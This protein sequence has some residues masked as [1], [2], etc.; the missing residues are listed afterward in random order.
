MRADSA[1]S[2]LPRRSAHPA[3][4]D[5]GHAPRQSLPV[6]LIRLVARLLA[7][8]VLAFALTAAGVAGHALWLVHRAGGPDPAAAIVVL[9]GGVYA[10]GSPGPDT[11]ARTRH[12]IA[13]YRAGLAP[14]LHFTGGH[15]NPD[16]PGTGEGMRAAA[17][18]A[19][20]PAAATSAESGSRSTLQNALLSRAALGPLAGAPVILVSDG[21]H[22]ARAWASFRWAGYGPVALSAATAFGEGSVRDRA[23]R[24]GREALAW[25]FNLGRAALW[26]AAGVVGTAEQERLEL[27]R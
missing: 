18:A 13:L 12:G 24:V 27:L 19:G 6:R 10:D 20:V 11:L 16:V 2:P 9:G 23:A 5:R 21:Y 4:R 7:G 14:H 3:D 25:W 1:R 8:L 22:L 17:L 26:H 15:R